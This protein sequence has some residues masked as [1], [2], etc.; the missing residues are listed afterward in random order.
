MF[1]EKNYACNIYPPHHC[2]DQ[3]FKYGMQKSHLYEILHNRMQN[4]HRS[5]D[6][7]IQFHVHIKILPFIWLEVDS[8]HPLKFPWY[9]C[10]IPFIKIS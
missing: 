6:N 4:L 5:L 1:A 2:I 9:K 7:I 3:K 10:S 8:D